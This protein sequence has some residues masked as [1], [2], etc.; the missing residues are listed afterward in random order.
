MAFV[1]SIFAAAVGA[2][3]RYAVA[4]RFDHVDV[5]MFGLILMIAGGAGLVLLCIQLSTRHQMVI[6]SG[7]LPDEH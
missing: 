5:R 4:D 2:V 6:V 7:D 3:L 1:I